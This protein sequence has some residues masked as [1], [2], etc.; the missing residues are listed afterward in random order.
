MLDE[1]ISY[2]KTNKF[3]AEVFEVNSEVHSAAKASAAVSGDP[4]GLVKSIL[5]IDYPAKNPVLVIL[6]GPDK[7][8]FEKV[9]NILGVKDVRM[10]TSEE[11]IEITGYEVGG[12]PPISIYGVTVILDKSASKKVEVISGGGDPMHLMRIKIQDIIEQNDD[13]LIE[14]VKK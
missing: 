4:N 1:L 2:I 9:K 12:V 3:N 5:L 10:A 8:D 6:L 13:I 14:D 7:I 11:V